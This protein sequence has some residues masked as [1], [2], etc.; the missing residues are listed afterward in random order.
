MMFREL[1]ESILSE[2]DAATYIR[3]SRQL[4]DKVLLG[5]LGGD[6]FETLKFVLA[7]T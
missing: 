2:E 3:I 7:S 6:R 5:A 4:P 1:R